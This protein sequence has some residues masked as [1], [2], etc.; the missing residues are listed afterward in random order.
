MNDYYSENVILTGV[1]E[2][3]LKGLNRSQFESR[4]MKNIRRRIKPWGRFKVFQSQSRIWI[5]PLEED[6]RLDKA[7]EE[8]SFVFGL[9]WSA[10][11]KR[12][13]KSRPAL[14]EMIVNY[15]KDF[16][17]Q[18]P[19]VKTFKV[20]ARRSDKS[21]ELDS[22]QICRQMGGLILRKFEGLKV[23]VHNPDIV[24]QV[25]IR[26]MAYVFVGK[27]AGLRGLPVGTSGKGMLM[28]SAGID[29]PVAGFKIASRG[30]NLEAV[31]FHTFPY[32]SENTEIK[33]TD[34]AKALSAY[35]GNL[36]LHVVDFTKIM[37][38]L[39]D[40]CPPEMLVVI[41]RRFMM[42]IAGRIALNRKALAVITGESLGQVASQTGQA[43]ICT[44]DVA[45]LPV[46]RPLIGLDKQEIVETARKIGTYEISIRPY[47]DCCTVFVAKHP[48]LSPS[49][50]E[51]ENIEDVMDVEALV[52]YGV[53]NTR[54]VDIRFEE[55]S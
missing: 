52:T 42:R 2:L 19:E 37:L 36:R 15:L 13:E 34:L 10:Q 41:M 32:T 16:L 24:V 55:R 12:G 1:G 11:A 5:I 30:M 27:E 44:D 43:L 3:V 50:S 4:L 23:D 9:V 21:F 22:P 26:D 53:E 51:C 38:E 25:E 35:T 54:T 28:L 8:L 47:E 17:P 40:K 18:N 6:C 39:R 14:E 49:V 48:R 31:Y 45:V 20:E 33:V 7:M 46:Y 29:S